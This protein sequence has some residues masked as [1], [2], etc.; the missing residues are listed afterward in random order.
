MNEK[1]TLEDKIKA[2][3]LELVIAE[4]EMEEEKKNIFKKGKV[5]AYRNALYILTGKSYEPEEKDE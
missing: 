4:E 1:N 2:I 3:E 5:K